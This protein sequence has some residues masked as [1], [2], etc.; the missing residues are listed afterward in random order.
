[1]ALID[2]YNLTGSATLS[3]RICAACWKAATDVLNE[4]ENTANHANRTLWAKQV[5]TEN[6]DG[7]MVRRLLVDCAQNA[8]IAA[9]GEA[10]TDNDLQFVVNSRINT[11]ADGV[12]GA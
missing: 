3:S 12:Y 8:S 1:M 11:Y 5:L 10:A 2:Q 7:A 9:A 4:A 6:K